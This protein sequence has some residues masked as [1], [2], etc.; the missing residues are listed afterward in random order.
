M[1]ITGLFYL[2]FFA[3]IL[4]AVIVGVFTDF[5][6][7]LITGFV[8]LFINGITFYF[9]QKIQKIGNHADETRK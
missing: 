7:G 5:V 2:L 4:I 9:V 8:L 1:N 6:F 3:D